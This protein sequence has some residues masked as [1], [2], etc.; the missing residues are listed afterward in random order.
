MI[1][2]FSGGSFISYFMFIKCYF[3]QINLSR[4][5]RQFKLCYESGRNGTLVGDKRQPVGE[6]GPKLG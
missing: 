3:G 2:T 1:T 6:L 4:L 5:L